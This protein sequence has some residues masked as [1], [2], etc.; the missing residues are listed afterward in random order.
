MILTNE[1]QVPFLF[2]KAEVIIFPSTLNSKV[3]LLIPTVSSESQVFKDRTTC[4]YT[5]QRSMARFNLNNINSKFKLN[6]IT[7]LH[8]LCK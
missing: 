7:Q 1:S 4:T 8:L 5:Y 6:C 2:E 3:L